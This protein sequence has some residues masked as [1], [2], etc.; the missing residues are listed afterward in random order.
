MEEHV[1]TRLIGTVPISSSN[2]S[3][4]VCAGPP[5]VTQVRWCGTLSINCLPRARVAPVLGWCLLL[6]SSSPPPSSPSPVVIWGLTIYTTTA[7]WLLQG[8]RF[9][10][11]YSL[12][13]HSCFP[14]SH[15]GTNKGLPSARLVEA[16]SAPV[17]VVSFVSRRKEGIH[18]Q[19]VRTNKSAALVGPICGSCVYIPSRK[20]MAKRKGTTDF[21][22]EI[23]SGGL[24]RWI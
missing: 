20:T 23:Y 18:Q 3:G 12:L 15:E 4:G 11:V 16:Q 6:S 22:A 17:V 21:M 19:Q 7:T 1:I 9:A 13:V 14:V 2:S 8:S 5:H 24:G 10:S